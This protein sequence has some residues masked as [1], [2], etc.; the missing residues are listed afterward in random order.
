MRLLRICLVDHNATMNKATS[1]AHS[2]YPGDGSSTRVGSGRTPWPA[3]AA[4][5]FW[6]AAGLSAGYWVLQAWGRAPVTPVPAASS[7]LPTVDNGSVA[8][9]LGAMPAARQAASQPAPV[10][11]RYAL[12][13]VVA[14]GTQRG[15]A[16]IAI[17][18]KPPLPYRVGAA[19]E[20]GLVLQAVTG[21]EVRLGPTAD[22]PPTVT[23]AVPELPTTGR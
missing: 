19:L 17:D 9:A 2:V 8:R 3:V 1:F 7:T 16:L 5:V 14:V 12:K 10:A 22:D 21:E 20:G 18:G 15:A 4:G 23:L 13:G 6:L 11:S